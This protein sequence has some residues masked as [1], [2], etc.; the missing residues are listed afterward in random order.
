MSW[1]QVDVSL[2]YPNGFELKVNWSA[3]CDV[4]AVMGPS[5]SGK[6]TFLSLIAGFLRPQSG[7]ISVGGEVVFDSRLC[8]SHPP[9]R[10]RIGFVFQE[11]L[12]FPHLT[13]RQNL[14]YGSPQPTRIPRRIS[15]ERVVEML[16]IESLLARHPAKLS[17]GERQRVALG[18]ALLSQPRALLLD[19]PLAA[20]DDVLRDRIVRDLSRIQQEFALPI[21]FVSHDEPMVHS[22]AQ[23]VLRLQQGSVV[24]GT[25]PVTE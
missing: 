13:V 18:R 15:L 14:L 10:R 22:F 19:E 25:A 17:G 2:R 5:G 21:L 23:E 1:L 12:L 7:R 11:Y 8:L 9:E 6:T 4:V 20:L 16:Q 24:V 3:T